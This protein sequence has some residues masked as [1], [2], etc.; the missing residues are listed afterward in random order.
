VEAVEQRGDE[1]E[2]GGVH[3]E[4]E[5]AERDDGDRQ[6]EQD[7]ERA[8]HRVHEAVEEGRHDQRAGARDLDPAE[9]LV[10]EPEPEGGDREADREAQHRSILLAAK[11]REPREETPRRPHPVT[12]CPVATASHA[13]RIR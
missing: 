3:D 6:R 9:E 2:H 11:H 4:Q 12:S 8:D 7:R 1:A 5:E 10:G 13:A